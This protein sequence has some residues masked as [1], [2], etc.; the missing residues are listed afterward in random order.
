ML[1]TFVTYIG[2]IISKKAAETLGALILDVKVGKG[3]VM[4]S[5]QEAEDLARNLVSI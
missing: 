3:A 4:K 2:S 5:S 1:D